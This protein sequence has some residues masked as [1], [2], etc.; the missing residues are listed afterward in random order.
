MAHRQHM[1]AI[2]VWHKN[3][4]RQDWQMVKVVTY[5]DEPWRY[6]YLWL[7]PEGSDARLMM[8]GTTYSAWLLNGLITALRAFRKELATHLDTDLRPEE[9]RPITGPGPDRPI[10]NP[11]PTVVPALPPVI[12]GEVIMDEDE[13][14]QLDHT[15]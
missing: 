15:V 13:L 1:R 8:P 5:R 3:T 2:R 4:G 11:F 6:L 7:G 12:A 10:P 14:A 9:P